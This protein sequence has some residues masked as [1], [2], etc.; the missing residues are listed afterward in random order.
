MR[1]DLNVQVDLVEDI[2]VDYLN[3]MISQAMQVGGDLGYIIRCNRTLAKRHDRQHEAE[4]LGRE[5]S[6]DLM[7]YFC[8]LNG[9]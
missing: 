7:Q 6:R 8:C 5:D 9:F 3:E 1:S 4:V 2:A